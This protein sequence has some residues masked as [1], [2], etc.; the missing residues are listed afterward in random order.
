M[1]GPGRLAEPERIAEAVLEEL[2]P[3]RDLEGETVLV[4]AGPT[5]EPLDPV[6]FLSNHSSGKQ[7]YAIAKALIE[8][9]AAT[10]L[11]ASA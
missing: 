1:I 6:R 5:Q 10:T 8:A 4:T 9:G 11:V 3:R 2:N 7:G